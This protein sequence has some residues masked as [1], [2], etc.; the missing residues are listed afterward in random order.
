MVDF[1]TDL[2]SRIV[3]SDQSLSAFLEFGGYAPA[4]STKWQQ[5]F[6]EIRVT[7]QSKDYGEGTGRERTFQSKISL[8]TAIETRDYN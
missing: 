8:M 5:P 7:V 6:A 1:D 4:E 3:L 2:V